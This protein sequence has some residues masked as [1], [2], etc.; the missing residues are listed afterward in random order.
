MLTLPRVIHL[1]RRT[2]RRRPAPSLSLNTIDEL[3]H[4]LNRGESQFRATRV[5]HRGDISIAI[6]TRRL[7]TNLTSLNSNVVCPGPNP[8]GD[9]VALKLSL[10]HHQSYVVLAERN[11]ARFE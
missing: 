11:S 3:W 8:N 1:L 5:C 7:G 10:P 2:R 9:V 6:E 4:P